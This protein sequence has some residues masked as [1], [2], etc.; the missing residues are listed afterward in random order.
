ME[1][2]IR[3]GVDLGK[4]YFR[5]HALIGAEGQ[6][7]TR[8]LT[9]QAI[10]RVLLRDRVRLIGMEAGASPHYWARELLAMG[11]DGASSRPPMSSL[12]SNGPRTM[13]PMRRQSARPARHVCGPYDGLRRNHSLVQRTSFLGAPLEEPLSAGRAGPRHAGADLQ[14]NKAILPYLCT[15]AWHDGIETAP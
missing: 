14:Q 5:L 7:K 10:H 8:K 4:N 6:A 9:R 12:M 13:P 11:H 15:F 1:K 3:I 2:F